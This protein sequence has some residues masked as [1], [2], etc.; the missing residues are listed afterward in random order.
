MTG[1]PPAFGRGRLRPPGRTEISVV[2]TEPE[3]RG[4]GHA[5][6]LLGLLV[7]RVLDRHER[8]FL[9]VAEE[10]T[11]AMALYERL[12]FTSRKHVTFRGFRTP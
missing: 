11:A 10:D 12:G 3:A 5:A 4:R 8:P 7:A 6:H 2:R 1:A 9:R